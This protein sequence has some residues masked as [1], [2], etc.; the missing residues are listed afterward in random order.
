MADYLLRYFY[1]LRRVIPRGKQLHEVS[2]MKL[3]TKVSSGKCLCSKLEVTQIRM[4]RLLRNSSNMK[5]SQKVSC[6]YRFIGNTTLRY[7]L[8]SYNLVLRTVDKE[9][10][11]YNLKSLVCPN[12]C[13][14]LLTLSQLDARN[15]EASGLSCRKT[16]LMIICI[17]LFV[18]C[19]YCTAHSHC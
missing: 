17:K 6:N 8:C 2:F 1:L 10:V 19:E 9:G 3:E 13:Q 15:P 11:P 5:L 16:K 7:V 12:W 18:L 14:I 4:K